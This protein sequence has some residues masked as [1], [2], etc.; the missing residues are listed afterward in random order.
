MIRTASFLMC[1]PFTILATLS[2][3]TLLSGCI[4]LNGHGAEKAEQWE[5]LFDGKSTHKWRGYNATAFPASWKI[6]NGALKAIP[7]NGADLLTK[8]EYDNFELRLEWKVAPG[9]NSGILYRGTEGDPEIWWNAPEMQVLDDAKHNDGK[10]PK[11]SAGSLYALIAPSNKILKPVGEYNEIRLV[12]RG[13]H[14]EHWLNNQKVVEYELGS[15]ELNALIAK[16]KFA[17]KPRYGKNLSGH[18]V[19]QHH[20]DEVW[21]R[22]IRIRK[23]DPSP[24]SKP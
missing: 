11:T 2:L 4:S 5:V 10:N 21:Y 1:K 7:G 8:A 3:L 18:I 19:L 20:H 17:D 12:A 23:L 6:E 15:P 16:S 13:N 14:I 24:G 22:N 9:A